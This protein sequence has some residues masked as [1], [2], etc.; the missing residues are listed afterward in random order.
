VA[1]YLGPVVSQ[2]PS[3]ARTM[4]VEMLATVEGRVLW[5]IPTGNMLAEGLATE[6][7]FQPV[8]QLLR[9]WSGAGNIAGRPDLQFALLD[10]TSG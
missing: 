7:G 5:D 2:A 6:H 10:P 3:E 9:M 4:I 8:R 1:T